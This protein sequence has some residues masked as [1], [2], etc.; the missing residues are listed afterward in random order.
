MGLQIGLNSRMLTLT[1]LDLGV[2][3]EDVGMSMA[4]AMKGTPDK[5]LSKLDKQIKSIVMVSHKKMLEELETHL[6]SE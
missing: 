5:Y 4:L 1:M 6:K 2:K 3:P